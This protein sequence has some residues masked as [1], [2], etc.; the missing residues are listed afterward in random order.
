MTVRS[1]SFHGTAFRGGCRERTANQKSEN[2]TN[3]LATDF[4]DCAEQTRNLG[5]TGEA[6]KTNGSTEKEDERKPQTATE[7]VLVSVQSRFY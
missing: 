4:A 1:V 3:P 6:A 2:R 5:K 7:V